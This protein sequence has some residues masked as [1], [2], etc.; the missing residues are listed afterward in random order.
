VDG[1]LAEDGADD[2]EVED[3]G[4]WALFGEAFNGLEWEFGLV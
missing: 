3:V 1:E 4:L 2:V